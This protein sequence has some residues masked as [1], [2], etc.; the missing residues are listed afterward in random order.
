[1]HY[2]TPTL[3]ADDTPQQF[4]VRQNGDSGGFK[5]RVMNES[6]GSSIYVVCTRLYIILAQ[7]SLRW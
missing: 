2:V 6:T 1:M 5:P 4:V 7:F 3:H